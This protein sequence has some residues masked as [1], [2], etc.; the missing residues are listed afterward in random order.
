MTLPSFR[1]SASLLVS[2][3]LVVLKDWILP[4]PKTILES[5]RI[6]S[7]LPSEKVQPTYTLCASELHYKFTILRVFDLA[8]GRNQKKRLS[9]KISGCFL[10]IFKV[11]IY[12][13]L[14]QYKGI[15]KGCKLF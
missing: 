2:T 7:L 12:N 3:K 4:A 1:V 15:G 14:Q 5:L 11:F 6:R 8:M 9:F 13:A 10:N